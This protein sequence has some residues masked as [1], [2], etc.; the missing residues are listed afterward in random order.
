MKTE[1]KSKKIMYR[2]E[3]YIKVLEI[4]NAKTYDE[5]PE[6][7]TDGKLHWY[8]TPGFGIIKYYNYDY[9]S[10][11]QWIMEDGGIYLFDDFKKMIS[12]MKEAGELLSVF[13]KEISKEAEQ[14]KDWRGKTTITI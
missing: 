12:E 14:N 5:L 4:R 8:K 6:R 7:Y 1:I 9:G 11:P 13:N 10:D 2:G 3:R